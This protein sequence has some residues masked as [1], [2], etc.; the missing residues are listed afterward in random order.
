MT[1]EEQLDHE[2]RIAEILAIRRAGNDQS[3]LNAW[4]NSTVL[5]TLVGVVGTGLLGAWVSGMIQDRSKRNELERVAQDQKL[6]AQNAAVSKVLELVGTSVTTA[7][8]LLVT[9]NNAY[10]EEGRSADDVMKLRKWKEELA[11][12]RDAADLAW[13]REKRSLGFTIMYLFDG[14]ATVT[15]AWRAVTTKADDFERCTNRWYTENAARLTD[16]TADQICPEDRQA[17]ENAVETF[18]IAVAARRVGPE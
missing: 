17:V 13:R 16:L 10:G 15:S 6:S 8:D 5:A 7:D 14:D 3:K 18:M 2:R 4:L 9:V 1:H 12:R 11:N